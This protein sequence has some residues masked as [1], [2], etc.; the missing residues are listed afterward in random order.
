MEEFCPESGKASCF[1]A[2]HRSIRRRWAMLRAPRSATA[3]SGEI[4]CLQTRDRLRDVL[5]FM[6]LLG[7]RWT[8]LSPVV[9]IP[10]LV[11]SLNSVGLL[12]ARMILAALGMAPFHWRDGAT[13]SALRWA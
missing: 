13:S 2:I 8:D 6:I 10:L 4:L 5:L 3:V 1:E 7:G 9:A 12:V 11:T